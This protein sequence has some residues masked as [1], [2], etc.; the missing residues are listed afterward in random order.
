MAEAA[1]ELNLSHKMMIS[2]AYHDSLFMARISPM[3][4]IFIP[5][6]KGYSHKPEEYSSPEDMANGV[7]VLSLALAKLSLD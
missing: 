2:R 4:M 7:K 5:C 1:T 3:G 6:Y